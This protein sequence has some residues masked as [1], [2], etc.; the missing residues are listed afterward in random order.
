MCFLTFGSLIIAQVQYNVGVDV[1]RLTAR[2][3]CILLS[4]EG[5]QMANTMSN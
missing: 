5:W 3:K 2:N 4:S 1:K